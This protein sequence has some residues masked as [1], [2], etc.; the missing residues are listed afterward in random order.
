MLLQ[1]IFCSKA[2]GALKAFVFLACATVFIEIGHGWEALT[3]FVTDL[4]LG[5]GP[6]L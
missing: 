1:F 2:K 3:T 5:C 4:G 6:E